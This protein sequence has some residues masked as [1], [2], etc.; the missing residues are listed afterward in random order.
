V[1]I[2]GY[3]GI[4]DLRLQGLGRANLITGKNNT[5]KSSVL[6]AL[7]ILA[8]GGNLW[9]L[10]QILKSR[11]EVHDG[12]GEPLPPADPEGVFLLTSLFQGHPVFQPSIDPISISAVGETEEFSIRIRPT[13]VSPARD[14]D[15][16]EILVEDTEPRRAGQR[17]SLHGMQIVVNGQTDRLNSLELIQK[18]SNLALPRWMPSLEGQLMPCRLVGNSSP[19]SSNMLGNLWDEAVVSG[20]DREVIRGLQ[21]IDPEVS[22][23]FLVGGDGSRPRTVMVRSSKHPRAVPIRSYGDGMNRLFELV[24]C[25]VSAA[26]GLLLIDEFETGLHHTV[27]LDVWRTVFRLAQELEVQVFA[28]THSWDTVKAFQEAAGESEEEGALL[29]LVRHREQIVST[30][31][32]EEELAIVTDE[33]FEVR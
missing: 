32:D 24:L 6:E 11:E 17:P 10:H 12:R 4:R 25:L 9:T 14:H 27:Q 33:Q 15:G 8:S 1:T 20:A 31:F 18:Y 30:V 22:S 7:E 26:G 19:E 28:T 29:R 13:W 23:V 3:R 5:G 2:Q 16:R 21:L